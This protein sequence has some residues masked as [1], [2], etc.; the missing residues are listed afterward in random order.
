MM[1]ITQQMMKSP[2]ITRLFEKE[3]SQKDDLNCVMT[4]LQ[5]DRQLIREEVRQEYQT[6]IN[7]ERGRK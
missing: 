6:I 1:Q 7:Q 3:I 5:S 4:K 2:G